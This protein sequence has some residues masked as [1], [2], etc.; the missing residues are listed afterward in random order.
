MALPPS[1]TRIYEACLVEAGKTLRTAQFYPLQ[2]PAFQR[3]LER[4]W[5]YLSQLLKRVGKLE[6]TITKTAPFVEGR[7]VTG[8]TQV[9]A[10]L[11]GECFRRRIKVIHVETTATQADLEALFKVLT[12]EPR[13]LVAAGGPEKE[14]ARAGARHLWTNTARF[15]AQMLADETPPPEP[16]DEQTMDEIMGGDTPDGYAELRAALEALARAPGAQDTR[17]LLSEILSH[18]RMALEARDTGA[19]LL[20]AS[21]LARLTDLAADDPARG[22]AYGKAIA[23][24]AT[25]AVVEAMIARLGR[26]PETS[27][28]SWAAPLRQ[29]GPAAVP[30]LLAT[31]ASSNVRKERLRALAVVR[32]FGRDARGPVLQLLQDGRWFVV[33]NALELLPDVGGAELTPAAAPFLTYGHAR[34]RQSARQSLRRLGGDAALAALIKAAG[35]GTDDERRHAVSQL[36]F[37][38][39][40]TVMPIVLDLI[41]SGSPG[42]AEEALRVLGEL[43][44]PD[45]L[46]FLERLLR[47]RGGL[48]GRR[49]R[50]TLR[51]TAAE[52]ICLRLPDTWG[53]LKQFAEDSDAEIRKWVVRGVEWMKRARKREAQQA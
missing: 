34:V 40:A 8:N 1:P 18:A 22:R 13:D 30:F 9:L 26:A 32:S 52:L 12:Q 45:L 24:M 38:P 49:R 15:D 47:D 17:R 53:I 2:H 37:F 36:G 16:L 48:L 21:I 4:S 29:V 46:D 6:I 33:R 7:Q 28:E 14:M 39:A 41:E 35:E 5:L 42:V 10:F 11:A 3:S 44:P 20:A 31:M 51:R 43:E 27:W 50:D 19:A 23:A 25:P